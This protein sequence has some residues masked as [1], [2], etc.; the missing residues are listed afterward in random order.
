MTQTICS[1]TETSE[2]QGTASGA[3]ELAYSRVS[4][5]ADYFRG[6]AG[7]ALSCFPLL[8]MRP[9]WPIGFGLLTVLSLEQALQRAGGA[10]GNKGIEAAEAAMETLAVLR[11]IKRAAKP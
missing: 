9:T 6:W 2:H 5:L 11:R 3:I 7:L 1:G 4:M 10:V 8:A